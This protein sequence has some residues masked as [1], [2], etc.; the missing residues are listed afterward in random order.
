MNKDPFSDVL[1]L[2]NARSV[3][4]GGFW[5]GGD[6]AI[7]FPPPVRVKFFIAARGA[8]WLSIDGEEPIRFSDGDAFLLTAARGFSLASDPSLPA[9]DA[10]T[11][12]A[13]EAHQILNLG[14]GED[15]FFL[16]GH[17]QFDSACGQL[18]VD[19]LPPMIH[20]RAGCVEAST[21]GW[22]IDQLVC[23]HR[24][25][26]PGSDFA[27]TQLAQL[28]F[29]HILRSYLENTDRIMSGRLRAISDPRIA[30]AIRLIHGDPGYQWHLPELAAACAMSR[31]V[32]AGY[33]KSVAGVAPLTYLTQWRMH[34]AERA[35][36]EGN[37]S[38][39]ELSETLGYS[40]ESAFSVAF[41]RVTGRA[42]RRYKAAMRQ[43][44]ERDLS[45]PVVL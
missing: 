41:K 35:L 30:P 31:T 22:L 26:R 33:F 19:N 17:V 6:W 5:A 24:R 23:E 28:M 7:R 1:A 10:V 38:L 21:I 4:S 20:L 40:S 42:P 13:G 2:V 44:V 39:A 43:N 9:L 29:L 32:F 14:E 45:L 37:A 27:A 36:R 34:L 15:F 11:L 25:G 3:I 18:L 8:C 16:G 12:Y